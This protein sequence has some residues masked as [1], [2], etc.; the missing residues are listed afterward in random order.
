MARDLTV[1]TFHN[2]CVR[3]LRQH[4]YHFGLDRSFTIYDS[5]DQMNVI[6]RAMKEL[7]LDA[8]AASAA[9]HPQPDLRRQECA[10][11]AG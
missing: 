8:E 10:R 7:D 9:R 5:D 11:H 1:G 2:F 3:V 6:K 4:G